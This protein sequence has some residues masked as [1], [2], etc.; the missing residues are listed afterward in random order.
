MANQKPAD[1][2]VAADGSGNYTTV[3]AAIAAA[4][5][6]SEKPFS[7]HIKRGLYNEF[8]VVPQD[9]PNIVLSGDGMDATVISGSRCCADG[10]NTQ[11]TAILTV[12]ASGFVGRDLCV[13]NTPGPR[14]DLGQAVAFLSDAD[15]SVLYRCALQSYQDT[16]YCRGRFSRQFFR[17]CKIAGTVDFIFGEA[18]AVFQNCNILARLPI[19]GQQNTITAQGRGSAGEKGGFCFQSCTVAADE[20]LAAQGKG[21]Q[22]FLG[23]PWKLFSRVVFVESILSEVI[24]PLG[25]LPWESQEPPDSI[26]YAE[27]DNKG[28]GAATG[29]RVK[30]RGFHGDLDAS[31][32]SEFTVDRFI[33]GGNWLPGTGIQYTPGL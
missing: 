32:A 24:D 18:A 3:N 13:K 5:S 1:V 29:G 21:V 28:A 8:V 11:D 19:L 30:W 4:P 14:K 22:T 17:E 20:D 9:K 25:W 6:K 26:F 2:V 33:D 12:H 16:L 23:R 31:Q 10:F 7:I 15:H 27:F